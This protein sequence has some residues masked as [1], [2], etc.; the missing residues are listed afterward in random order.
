MQA[1]EFRVS[2]RDN[3]A[4]FVRA[5]LPDNSAERPLRAIVLIAH[6]MAEHSARYARLAEALTSAGYAVYA[7]DH[8]GHGH[9]AASPADLGYFADTD[10]WSSVVSDLQE[11]LHAVR[12]RH[13]GVP[14]FLL[15][16]SMGSYIARG[17]AFRRGDA[18]AGLL[19][20]GT[21]HDYPIAYQAPRLLVAAER[22]RLGKRGKSSVVKKLTFDA[23]NKKFLPNRTGSD[24]LTRDNAEVDKYVNDPLC[25]FECSTQLWWDVLGGLAEICTPKNVARMPKT[26]P[27]YLLAG[28]RDPVN[29]DLSGIRKLQ[30]ALKDAGMESVTCRIYPE[31][32]HE[33]F[34][35]TNRDEITK[36]LMTWL[37]LQLT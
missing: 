7:N 17:L 15:G 9:T 14:V 8:R 2:A 18:L 34:N 16:H 3:T 30:T 31:A 22:A 33:L 23:F 13:P 27:I 5:F 1:S 20:S 11:V 24:W 37:D 10:G 4:L 28:E 29:N 32:R 36:D 21:T 35:E 26:L 6:G 19:L 25:S 12:A